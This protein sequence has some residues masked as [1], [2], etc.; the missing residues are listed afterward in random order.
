MKGGGIFNQ[1]PTLDL[2]YKISAIDA[3]DNV[4]FTGDEKGNIYR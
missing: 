1:R 4:M 2:N 3:F